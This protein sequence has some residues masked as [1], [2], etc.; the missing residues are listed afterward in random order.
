[1]CTLSSLPTALGHI[2]GVAAQMRGNSD[3]AQ[4]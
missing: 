4:F 1:M 2:T 3:R